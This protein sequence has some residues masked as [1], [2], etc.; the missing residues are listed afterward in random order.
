MSRTPDENGNSTRVASMT[1]LTHQGGIGLA[2]SG[3]QAH[4]A[5]SSMRTCSPSATSYDSG[6]GISQAPSREQTFSPAFE[7]STGSTAPPDAAIPTVSGTTRTQA[8]PTF[9]NRKTASPVRLNT[10]SK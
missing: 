3:D 5:R 2:D 9:V 10:V 8:S 7:T 4:D 6:S 1:A